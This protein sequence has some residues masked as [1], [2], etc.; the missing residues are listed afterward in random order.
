MRLLT[1]RTVVVATDLDPSSHVALS[2]AHR[3]AAH[4]GAA[5]HVIHV[6]PDTTAAGPSPA[7]TATAA[8]REALQ[9]MDVPLADVGVHVLPGPPVGTIGAFAERM[10]ADVVVLGPH[11]NRDRAARGHLLG[12][13]ARFVA[14][15]VAIPCL[16]ATRAL[17]LPLERVLVPTDF[18]ATAR[19][20]LLVGLS[21]ASGLRT[22]AVAATGQGETTLTAL[23]VEAAIG[24]E[25]DGGEATSRALAGEVEALGASRIDWAGVMI[26]ADVARGSDVAQ[27]IG[28]YALERASDLVVI[29]TR[30][31]GADDAT[32][33]GS[34][35]GALSLHVE[36]PTLLVPPAVWRVHGELG[37]R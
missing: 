5:L 24:D 30:G 17:R 15:E 29:G 26:E 9:M 18:S 22:G 2:V 20:A 1:L 13:T 4:A 10:A 23:H 27:A 35:S 36:V 6:V 19:G 8:V 37:G 11:R 12:G 21:W 34:V 7:D 33:L 14:G 25:T 28:R 3:L 16:V 31:A 32:G